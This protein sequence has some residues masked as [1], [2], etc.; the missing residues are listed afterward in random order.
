[1]NRA[2]LAIALTLAGLCGACTSPPAEPAA[3]TITTPDGTVCPGPPATVFKSVGVDIGFSLS[4]SQLITGT[5]SLNTDP[6]LLK[7]ASATARDERIYDYTRCVALHRDH[8]SEDQVIYMDTLLK[9]LS[10][11]PTSAQFIEWEKLHPVPTKGVLTV[12]IARTADFTAAKCVGG[13][14]VDLLTITDRYTL[15]RP[16]PFYFATALVQPAQSVLVYDLNADPQHPLQPS[17]RI[18]LGNNELLRWNITVARAEARVRYVWK[19]SIGDGD[20]GLGFKSHYVINNIDARVIKHARVHIVPL[21]VEPSEAAPRCLARSDGFSCQ[22]LGI[23]PD[24]ALIYFWRW[25]IW[26]NCPRS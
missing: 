22:G 17:Q 5:L 20:G 21:R 25:N 24:A 7:A 11:Q 23:E 3:P 4:F 16:I 9:F 2:G 15:S 18:N 19:N 26:D 14:R 8:L 1:M 13:R 10:T 12:D 6:T